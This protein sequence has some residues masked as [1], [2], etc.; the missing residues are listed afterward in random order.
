[1]QF[2]YFSGRQEIQKEAIL[3][4]AGYHEPGPDGEKNPRR[5]EAEYLVAT[6]EEHAKKCSGVAMP[7]V[8]MG[9]CYRVRYE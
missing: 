1:M 2:R 3:E 6:A 4:C 5:V 8:V 9:T 7:V